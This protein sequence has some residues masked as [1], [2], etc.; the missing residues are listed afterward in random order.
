MD[1]VPS[2]SGFRFGPFLVR[3]FVSR[4]RLGI[5]LNNVN[6]TVMTPAPPTVL[7][8]QDND[9]MR[10][11]LR[12]QLADL[13]RVRVAADGEAAWDQLRT[14]P[15]DILLSDVFLSGVTGRALCRRLRDTPELP[16][17]PVILLG[18]ERDTFAEDCVIAEEVLPKP[19]TLDE[20]R[21]RVDR[22]LPSRELPAIDGT[23]EAGEFLKAV[24][25]VIERRLHN[26]D[27]TV[28]DL[29]EA[30]GLSR[31]HLTRR[32]KAIV[33]TTPAALIRERRI[34]RAKVHLEEGSQKISDVGTTVGFRSASHFSQVFR[35][36]VGCPPTAYL[37]EHM[38]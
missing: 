27:F 22:Y 1:E 34:R 31:R 18:G 15:P 19:F 8:A 14:D 21:E 17:I 5:P 30:V 23:R 20:L 24:V 13:Y 11:F 12:K 37:K 16:S 32:L 33:G 6:S 38:S 9:E 35:D 36:K 4:R 25:R 3:S 2:A 29:A 7:L 26:P 10:A 28:G